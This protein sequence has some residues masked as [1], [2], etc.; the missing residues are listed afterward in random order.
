[1]K[2]KIIFFLLSCLLSNS[3]DKT[4]S[5]NNISY[6]DFNYM[7]DN[8]DFVSMSVNILGSVRNPGRYN[9]NEDAS[10]MDLI[11]LSGGTLDKANLK[12][13]YIYRNE[14]EKITI[15]LNYFLESGKIKEFKILP[16]D[17]IFIKQNSF[18]VFLSNLK[19][20]NT[21]VS[22]LNLYILVEKV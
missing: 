4:M 21:L 7:T 6:K 3:F 11:A 16:N 14:N 20:V 15:N 18:A 8:L 2:K 1:M 10:I 9:I 19:F 22:L 13:V 5:S 17:T 12:K